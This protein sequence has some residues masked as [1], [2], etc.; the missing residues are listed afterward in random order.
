VTVDVVGLPLQQRPVVHAVTVS[1]PR[2]GLTRRATD[3]VLDLLPFRRPEY[4]PIANDEADHPSAD[5][6][7]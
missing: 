7:A 2:W 5:R 4:R 1:G 3:V 6:G